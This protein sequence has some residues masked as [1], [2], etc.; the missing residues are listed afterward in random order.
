VVSLADGETTVDAEVDGASASVT[1][2]ALQA[3]TESASRS[4]GTTRRT[5][6]R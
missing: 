1:G 3:E 6:V 4:A 5:I 2:S